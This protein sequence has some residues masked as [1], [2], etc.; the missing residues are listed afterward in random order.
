MT[1]K[2]HQFTITF[3]IPYRRFQGLILFKGISPVFNPGNKMLAGS[4]I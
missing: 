1:G 2:I 4:S 3:S